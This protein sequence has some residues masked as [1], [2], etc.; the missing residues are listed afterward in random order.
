MLKALELVGFKSFADKT[1]FDFPSGITAVV[2]P[3]GSGKSNVV[4]AIKWVLGEQ[5]VKSLRGKE[6]VDV[7]FN[8]S[9]TRHPL[10]AAEATLVF[11]NSQRLLGI[12]TSE[13]HV[14]R[15]VYRSGEAE[16][17]LNREPC[18]LRDIRD[19]FSGTGAA[20][21]A[22]SVI[23][24]GKVDVMLQASPKERRLLFEEAAG[25]SRFKAKKLEALRRLERV[26]QNLLRLKDIVDEVGNRLRSVRLQA[27]KARRYKEY[28]DRLQ[29]LRTQVAQAD[30][31]RLGEKLAEL[32]V[33][34]AELA[35][36][37][38]AA[39][40]EAEQFEA[41]S[42]AVDAEL[43][44]TVAAQQRCEGRSAE[45][46][47]RIA[48]RELTIDDERARI[49]DADAEEARLLRQ[50][51]AMRVRAGDLQQQLADAIAA[52]A[53]AGHRQ[54]E[55]L[56][57]LTQAENELTTVAAAY[58]ETRAEHEASRAT[59][60]EVTRSVAAI[61]TEVASLIGQRDAAR[62]AV[63]RRIA[64][65][66]ELQATR[67]ASHAEYERLSRQAEDLAMTA[68][69][70]HEALVATHNEIVELQAELK[71]ASLEL[72]QLRERHAAAA[73]RTA[74]LE[75]LEARQE[76]LAAAT[77]EVL[78]LIQRDRDGPLR[79]VR[80]ML[81]DL[82]H[83]S[84]EMAPAIDAVLG[85][86]AQA[87]VVEADEAFRRWAQNESLR[88][89][90]RVRFLQM[91]DRSSA[92]EEPV[93]LE[94]LPGVHGRAVQYVNALGE[95]T[96][97][98]MR[99]L[100]R[101]W[102][103]ENLAAAFAFRDRVG[104][105]ASCVTLSGETLS[106][107]GTL[108][109]GPKH[110]AAGLISRRSELRVLKE[111][112]TGLTTRVET[113]QSVVQTLETRLA[114]ATGR[115]RELVAMHHRAVVALNECRL[116]VNAAH[117]RETQ[118]SEQFAQLT[119]D[120][121]QQQQLA[122]SAEQ[123]LAAAQ[124]KLDVARQRLSEVD[125]TTKTSRERVRSADERL[126]HAR[127][128]VTV[129]KVDA[130]KCEERLASLKT[131]LAQLQRDQLERRRS[132][133]DCRQQLLRSRQR[134]R[135]SETNVLAAESDL[136]SCYLLRESIVAEVAELTLRHE[137]QRVSR[138]ELQAAAQTSQ[139]LARS[140]EQQRHA[141]DLTANEVRHERTT[142]AA[143]LKEDYQVDL[144]AIETNPSADEQRQRDEVDQEIAELRRK[145][146]HIGTVNLDALAEL[147]ELE[148]RHAT[149]A[150]QFQDLS[151]A[152]DSLVQII[153]K[154]NADSRRLFV[155]TLEAVTANFQTLYRKL[156]GGGQADVVLEEGVDVLESGIEIVA[157]PPG[158]ELRSVS[159]LSG[160]E[161]T[162]TCV[163]LLLAIFQYRPSPFC[164]LDEVDA[165]LDEANIERFI[166]VL[167]EF[168]SWTQFII[169]TH[170][171]KT[172]TC[173]GTLY[174]VTMGESGVSKR[175]SVRFDDVSE[176]GQIAAPIRESA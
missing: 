97:L 123:S 72:T 117:S 54:E 84:V 50:L 21:E 82:I 41:R 87:F 70:H 47:E 88:L 86:N 148:S 58:D 135:Q 35:G 150:A 106:D 3:N 5:S 15:R 151:K 45:N 11:D 137:S 23:E 145:I 162:L 125:V 68:D 10:N 114:D 24:Q 127:Q 79:A 98:V 40:A 48:S 118:L 39:L 149:L 108:S 96:G 172:M 111:Q 37:R 20:T 126:Q 154:I 156:F 95:V 67:A 14:T 25:I 131:H 163:A 132:V 104:H 153:G 115:E 52:V 102:I 53:D 110:T 9:A 31:R 81:A 146:N 38:D 129:A 139:S 12:D 46:R 80:G 16:Y 22:Y 169:V 136:A 141:K 170:S 99:L 133:E 55:Q 90:G 71:A 120:R 4:D 164:V 173:A 19:L 91:R 167:Q 85:E 26:D 144:A 32:E 62:L 64:Q 124:E 18:R 92:T 130:A 119:A 36:K 160:G 1:H 158:K 142:L 7:I 83:V 42:L 100:G 140:F 8:G 27:T 34:L 63:T 93:D 43:L 105:Q 28:A 61:E 171:K 89:A 51:A 56:I 112:I 165:A 74:L 175:V 161:K 60:L 168:L 73:E 166:G 6:M 30:W 76:G 94:N 109:I 59:S 122:N 103:V 176:D 157:R 29:Q 2:G 13:V 152:K 65:L 174:G 138:G 121:E 113:A 75:E 57:S 147:E 107:D 17:L 44:D 101:T 49:H 33:E 134:R 155:E 66:D 77:K 159:L 143:R 78:A 116:Q 128:N 69:G